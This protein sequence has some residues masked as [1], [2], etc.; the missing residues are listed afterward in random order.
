MHH[1]G[2]EVRWGPV[3]L[4]RHVLLRFHV[5]DLLQSEFPRL[6]FPASV[7]HLLSQSGQTS[8]LIDYLL[9]ELGDLSCS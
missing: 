1:K 6:G 7:Q 2:L 9:E 5:L 4:E 8:D 3:E